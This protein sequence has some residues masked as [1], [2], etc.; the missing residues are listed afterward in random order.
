MEEEEERSGTL[1]IRATENVERSYLAKITKSARRVSDSWS[2]GAA[3][4]TST[5]GAYAVVRRQRYVMI[6]SGGTQWKKGDDPVLPK[7][8]TVRAT[9]KCDKR[10]ERLGQV[11]FEEACPSQRQTSSR[12]SPPPPGET[13]FLVSVVS[14]SFLRCLLHQ[15]R[16][17]QLR[18]PGTPQSYHPP[19]NC[20]KSHYLG[21][22]SVSVSVMIF[23]FNSFEK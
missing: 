8:G 1:T 9:P 10:D 4:T 13:S 6:R 16:V 12:A 17:T 22:R 7:T 5:I 19:P 23:K 14:T 15:R 3:T 2:H 11:H 20:Y 21:I 18:D